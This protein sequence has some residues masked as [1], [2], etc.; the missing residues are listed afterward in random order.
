M[1]IFSRQ[2]LGLGL[3]GLSMVLGS[4][5]APAQTPLTPD[6][7]DRPRVWMDYYHHRPTERRLG[8]ELLFGG[9]T[10]PIGRYGTDDLAHTNSFIPL[11]Q[12]LEADYALIPRTE[13]FSTAA[14]A[15]TDIALIFTPDAPGVLPE[16]KVISD[17]EIQVLD[18]F[19]RGGGSL[20]IMANGFADIETFETVRLL[21]LL[22]HFGIEWLELDTGPID[23]IIPEDDP[24]FVLDAPIHYGG[25]C[26]FRFT[27]R[28]ES[29]RTLLHAPNP[30]ADQP[31]P[32]NDG[33]IVQ[34]RPGRG[35][36]IVVGD[37]GSFT[38]NLDRPWIRNAPLLKQIFD[39]AR[40][41]TDRP[42][43]DWTRRDS[44]YR[45]STTSAVIANHAAYREI[46]RAQASETQRPRPY[47]DLY[48]QDKDGLIDIVIDKKTGDRHVVLRYRDD[49]SNFQNSEPQSSPSAAQA[50]YRISPQGRARL[51]AEHDE[52]AHHL[53]PD[54]SALFIEFSRPNPRIGDRW[55]RTI[56]FAPPGITPQHSAAPLPVEA[57]TLLLGEVVIDGRTCLH[58]KTFAAA[59]LSDLGLSEA[60][61]L[62]DDVSV[63]QTR[64]TWD[65]GG[66]RLRIQ[67]EHWLDAETGQLVKAV[68]DSRI[69]L[70][71]K[72]R[73]G[74]RAA[75]APD[76]TV[77]T[78]ARRSVW[79]IDE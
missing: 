41:S 73:D 28:A 23:W 2:W 79:I 72:P 71:L 62:P 18:G 9:L 25:G 6:A 69:V 11:I 4:T 58:L 59:W 30:T 49:D 31:Y 68:A 33:A 76:L 64:W 51:L 47:T 15:D 34:V 10:D 14:L 20:L 48:W 78:T 35:K 61:L 52:S 40:P 77:V 26:L 37:T 24:V 8:R 54:T 67:L 12:T 42:T 55:N 38:A 65:R 5:S 22:R 70:F 60:D 19:V 7:P 45:L 63:A 56:A 39:H 57:Q 46:N 53:P 75:D 21:K 50:T 36:V 1:I 17:E 27:P 29:P 3:M 74:H 32:E 66:G 16:A 44:R 43:P 13:P